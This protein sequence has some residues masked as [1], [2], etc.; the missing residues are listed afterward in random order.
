MESHRCFSIF[1][2]LLAA[3]NEAAGGG[4]LPGKAGEEAKV[5]D[6]GRETDETP[7]PQ[8]P[9]RSSF[10]HT[11]IWRQLAFSKWE[12]GK[13]PFFNPRHAIA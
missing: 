11:G 1:Q 12:L 5:Q 8:V 10:L 9:D 7:R 2:A 6:L 3:G 4:V 13:I